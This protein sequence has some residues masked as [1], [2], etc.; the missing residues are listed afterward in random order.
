MPECKYRLCENMFELNPGQ[1]G[2]KKEYC[3]PQ[4]GK[5][6]RRLVG[7]EVGAA[8]DYKNR[9]P[10]EQKQ[11]ARVHASLNCLN[12]TKCL[13][14]VRMN[15]LDCD[16]AEYQADAFRLEPGM[17]YHNSGGENRM[18]LPSRGSV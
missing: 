1:R 7:L 6:E 17:L 18:N 16:K 13:F 14:G 3:C 4:H 12:Y 9:V 8:R 15:C 2:Q 11:A 10:A 5:A